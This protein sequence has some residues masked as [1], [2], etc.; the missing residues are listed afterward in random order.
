MF[1]VFIKKKLKKT[2]VS[3][4]TV[5]PGSE[6]KG[7]ERKGKGKG[8]GNGKAAESDWREPA[9]GSNHGAKVPVGW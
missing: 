6:K 8:K 7:R 9:L 3:E 5:A 2:G 4:N 1:I